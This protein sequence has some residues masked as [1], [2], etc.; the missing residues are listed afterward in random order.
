MRPLRRAHTVASWK[1]RMMKIYS[2]E[3]THKK[4]GAMGTQEL[5]L[6]PYPSKIQRYKENIRK[7]RKIRKIFTEKLYSDFYGE[8]A[9]I[10]AD[11]C[12]HYAGRTQC[13]E[14]A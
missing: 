6:R 12:A 4:A 14:L 5:N 9:I 11:T 10:C 13:G 7:E 2:G 3:D 8:I 1:E